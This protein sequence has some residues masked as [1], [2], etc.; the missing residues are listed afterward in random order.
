M[1][2]QEFFLDTRFLFAIDGHDPHLIGTAATS[3]ARG[4]CGSG[5]RPLMLGPLSAG[6]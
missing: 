2:G 3:T 6:M 1:I 4:L 5:L